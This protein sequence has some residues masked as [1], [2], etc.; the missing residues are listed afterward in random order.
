MSSG[1]IP[2]LYLS[3]FVITLLGIEELTEKIKNWKP[4][5][6][7]ATLDLKSLFMAQITKYSAYFGISTTAV[8]LKRLWI[9]F[10]F[11]TTRTT[12]TA[13]NWGFSVN[14]IVF[15]QS[16]VSG[17]FAEPTENKKTDKILNN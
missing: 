16:D 7:K 8:K 11:Q 2:A 3:G 14:R 9:E 12:Y 13:Q 17:K 10:N 6:K 5:C 4:D 1:T 15:S